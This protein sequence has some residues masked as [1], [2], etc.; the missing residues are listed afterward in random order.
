MRKK[1]WD[2][3]RLEDRRLAAAAHILAG[4]RLKGI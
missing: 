1:A 2:M 4:K 3:A